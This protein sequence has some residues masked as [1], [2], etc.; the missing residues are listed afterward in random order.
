MLASVSLVWGIN[1]T[2]NE[3][4]LQEFTVV[5][6]NALRFA[7]AGPALLALTGA[8]EGSVGMPRR[9][10][11]RLLAS[12]LIGIVA[13]Q[14]AFSTAV[15]WTTP[16][17]AAIL[18]AL[19][20]FF[21]TGFAA[22]AG[23][24]TQWKRTVVAAM[25]AFAGVVLV[26]LGQQHDGGSAPHP[27]LGDLVALATGVL[28]GA[29][30]VV[31][32]P[33]L[34]RHSPMR[35]TGW[36]GCIGAALMLVAAGFTGITH[37]GQHEQAWSWFSLAYS[38]LA[39][40]IYGLVAWYHGVHRVGSAATMLF[41]YAVPVAAAVFAVLVGQQ[42][43]TWPVLVGAALVLTALAYAQ[44]LFDPMRRTLSTPHTDETH[45]LAQDS[46]ESQ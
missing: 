27:I 24:R 14:L 18:V 16:T 4:G 37:G 39:V 42:R 9:Q 38:V 45:A 35:V 11:P 7:I 21:S 12:T 1:Y 5:G 43:I 22:L 2:I 6:F 25:G 20:P 3:W 10:W 19:S 29:Y 8:T 31:T 23:E 13:Y 32:R 41:M 36:A 28:W 40:T 17:E 26:V 34:A 33:L 46:K 44:G 30:P 15:L